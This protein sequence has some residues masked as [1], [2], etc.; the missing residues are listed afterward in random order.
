MFCVSVH[1]D[2]NRDISGNRASGILVLLYSGDLDSKLVQ[3]SD[4]GDMFDCQMV[5]NS[6]AR[7]HDSLVFRSPFA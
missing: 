5:P 3:Y 2:G 7:Y 6:D 1:D 4:H